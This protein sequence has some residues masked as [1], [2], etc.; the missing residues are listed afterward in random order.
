MKKYRKKN[1]EKIAESKKK[2]NEERK[3]IMEERISCACGSIVTRQNMSIHLDTERH[4]KYIETGKTINEL[5]KEDYVFCECG[6][7]ISKRGEKRHK[8][9]K[10]HKSYIKAN[11]KEDSINN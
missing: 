6:M 4:K 11:T 1:S 10:I 8:E 9:S 7:T 2:Y 5:R 3:E